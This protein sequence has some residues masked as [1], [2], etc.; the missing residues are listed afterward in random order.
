MWRAFLTAGGAKDAAHR[1]HLICPE[2]ASR[3]P[4]TM[5][6]TAQLLASPKTMKRVQLLRHGMPSYIHPES[7]GAAEV[8]ISRNP[9]FLSKL[10][11]RWESLTQRL[12][13]ASS[14]QHLQQS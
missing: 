11:P 4:A 13:T 10:V 3:L 14:E 2:N 1:L 12:V 6:L 8:C 9:A 7:M 5:G